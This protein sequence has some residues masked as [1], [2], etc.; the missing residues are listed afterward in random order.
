MYFIHSNTLH[1]RQSF[2]KSALNKN[3]MTITALVRNER[4]NKPDQNPGTHISKT[5]DQWRTFSCVLLLEYC[6]A[7]TT[8]CSRSCSDRM[9]LRKQIALLRIW[10]NSVV[11]NKMK[12]LCTQYELHTCSMCMRSKT[13]LSVQ[14]IADTLE[15]L[16]INHFLLIVVSFIHFLQSYHYSV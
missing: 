1:W 3:S 8:H 10:L 13:T 12:T 16:K 14:D 6:N 7:L 15:I 5:L 11:Y 9:E 2:K 4:R